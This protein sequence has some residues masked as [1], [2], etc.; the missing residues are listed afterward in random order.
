MAGNKSLQELHKDKQ[1]LEDE[2][3]ETQAIRRLFMHGGKVSKN[4]AI[5]L[6]VLSRF[7]S[8]EA[9]THRTLG[10]ST[11][12][13]EDLIRIMGRKEMYALLNNA[14]NVDVKITRFN[15]NLLQQVKNEI[16]EISKDE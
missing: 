9:T 8:M 2:L 14:I 10:G 15:K 4:G 1:T 12:S 11:A 3:R 6:D 13:G 16:E 5:V 7:A